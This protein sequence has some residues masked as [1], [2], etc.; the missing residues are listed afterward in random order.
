MFALLYYFVLRV[1]G[2]E[3][4][5]SL[6]VILLCCFLLSLTHVILPAKYTTNKQAQYRGETESC[7]SLGVNARLFI[8]GTCLF[9]CCSRNTMGTKEGPAG[10]LQQTVGIAVCRL[11]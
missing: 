5:L 4:V 10:L 3:I 8:H 6:A 1:G 9:V 11:A 2:I 7:P